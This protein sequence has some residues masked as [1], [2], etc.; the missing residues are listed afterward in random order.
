MKKIIRFQEIK[1]DFGPFSIKIHF[2]TLL[3]LL[4]FRLKVRNKNLNLHFNL[5]MN[6]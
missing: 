3:N 4:Y 1:A 6:Q 5:Q 2:I